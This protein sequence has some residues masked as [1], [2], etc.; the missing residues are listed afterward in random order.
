MPCFGGKDLETMFV[1]SLTTD[2]LGKPQPGT[3]IAF[4]PGVRGIPV[5]RFHVGESLRG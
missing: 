4:E 2:R 5:H 1:T 3:V